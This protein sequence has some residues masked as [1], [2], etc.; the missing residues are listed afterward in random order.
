MKIGSKSVIIIINI[1]V[2]V[3]RIVIFFVIKKGWFFC[4]W[5]VWLNVFMIV[6]ILFEVDY[7]VVMILKDNSFLLWELM[8]WEMLF[9]IMCSVCCGVIFL[10]RLSRFVDFNGKNLISVIKKIKKGN[11]ESSR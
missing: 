2:K 7:I 9:L 4:M 10:I 5:Y 1:I 11:S 6:L 8:I 3:R